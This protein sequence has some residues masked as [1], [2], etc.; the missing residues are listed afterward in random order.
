M[1][2]LLFLGVVRHVT[3]QCRDVA[4]ARS[5]YVV[6]CHQRESMLGSGHRH[7]DQVRVIHKVQIPLTADFLVQHGGKDHLFAFPALEFVYGVFN[8]VFRQM[9]S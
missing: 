4:V 6:A 5:K 2:Y 9:R 1:I 3:H 8:E 7:I